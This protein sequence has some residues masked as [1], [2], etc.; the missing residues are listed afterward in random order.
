MA[1]V[2]V[3]MG[4]ELLFFLL[5]DGRV[6][7][8]LLLGVLVVREVLTTGRV[9]EEGELEVEVDRVF[10]SD[11]MKN[12][13]CLLRMC[14]LCVCELLCVGCRCDDSNEQLNKTRM[15]HRK[16]ETTKTK[17]GCEGKR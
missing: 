1:V 13:I 3:V 10:L 16:G 11:M 12:K 7:L 9:L 17:D 4:D 5:L 15:A 14:V 8:L 6:L 2:A